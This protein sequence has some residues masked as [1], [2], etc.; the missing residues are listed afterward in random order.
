M[1]AEGR[2]P[3]DISKFPQNPNK[4]PPPCHSES[5]CVGM[6]NLFKR[7]NSTSPKGLNNNS[8][9]RRERSDRNP[10]KT[11]PKHPPT[12]SGLNYTFRFISPR[13]SDLP[14]LFK[15]LQSLIGHQPDGFT[16][17]DTDFL[18]MLHIVIGQCPSPPVFKPF[19]THL[20]PAD[21]K[22]PNILRPEHPCLEFKL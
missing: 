22:L 9:G 19:F 4:T 5:R 13:L 7:Q 10:G 14:P 1:K 21:H 20:I 8:P 16:Q 3:W 15:Y 6:R 11:I 18:V 17:C 2:N 12:P